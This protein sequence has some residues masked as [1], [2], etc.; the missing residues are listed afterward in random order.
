MVFYF[1]SFSVT[2]GGHS[3]RYHTLTCSVSLR[4]LNCI[5]T[6]GFVS[7]PAIHSRIKILEGCCVCNNDANA[8]GT[9]CRCHCFH[10]YLSS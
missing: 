10:C 8:Y 7:K 4:P 2:R 5:P 6:L 1:M 9:S 3:L